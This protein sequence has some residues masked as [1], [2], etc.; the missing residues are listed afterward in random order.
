MG[1]RADFYIGRGMEARWLGSVAMDGYPDGIPLPVRAAKTQGAFED[2]LAAFA[3]GCNHWSSPADGWPWPWKNSLTTNYAYAYDDGQVWASCF[4]HG[5]DPADEPEP[6]GDEYEGRGKTAT[7][8][9]MSDV[10]RVTFGKRSGM[11]LIRA[12]GGV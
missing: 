10:Q 12:K 6:E 11:M 1:T 9:D 8:P 3:Q 7:F 4:G 5:W 2:A